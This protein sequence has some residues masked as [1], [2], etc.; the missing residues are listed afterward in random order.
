MR[1]VPMA[2]AIVSLLLIT[3]VFADDAS[4]LAAAK[5]AIAAAKI[6]PEADLLTWCG[7]A[8]TLLASAEKDD[9]AKSKIASD[10]AAALFA[11][12]EP[13][14]TAD[15]VTDLTAM[16]TDYTTVAAAQLLT[17]TDKPTHTQ[18]ECVAAATPN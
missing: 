6:S 8:F 2:A 10:N 11:K 13:L 1:I 4:D 7:A 15:G 3:P 16:G 9:A 17:E 18:D 14:L 12:A 5:A